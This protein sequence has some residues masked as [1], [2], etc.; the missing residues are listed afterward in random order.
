IVTR[1]DGRDQPTNH[2]ML[3]QVGAD[4]ELFSQTLGAAGQPT[5]SV[6]SA[7]E[8]ALCAVA[9]DLNIKQSG[10]NTTRDPNSSF[11]PWPQ[12]LVQ[13][14][15]VSAETGKPVLSL[16]VHFVPQALANLKER[17]RVFPTLS[18][19]TEWY[20]PEADYILW[21]ARGEHMPPLG[22]VRISVRRTGNSKPFF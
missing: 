4:I 1:L 7:D 16:T 10:F 19:P 17:D 5:S 3:L 22:Q 2:E 20:L 13:V 8:A 14:R 12:A 9:R 11:S 21:A 15:T 18:S 6:T